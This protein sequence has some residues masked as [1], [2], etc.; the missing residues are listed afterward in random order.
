MK[1]LLVSD[2]EN[3]HIWDHFDPQRFKDV[4]LI[5]SCGD[6]QPRYLSF[7]VTMVN[8]PLFYVHGNHDTIYTNHLRVWSIYNCTYKGYDLGLGGSM[9]YGS[10]PSIYRERNGKRI[11]KLRSQL[12]KNDGFDIL[13]THAPA[14]SIGDGTGLCHTGFKSFLTLMDDYNPKFMFHGH[15]HLNYAR[16]NRI[17]QYKNTTIINGYEYYIVDV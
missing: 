13:V 7:L 6:M 8:V 3:D 17:N 16:V 12:R 15:M 4:D 14:F 5:I 11:R 1:I 10:S 9:K 2:K